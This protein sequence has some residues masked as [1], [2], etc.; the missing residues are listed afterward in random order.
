MEGNEKD[1]NEF[2]KKKLGST[3]TCLYLNAG[4]TMGENRSQ[5]AHIGVVG[6]DTTIVGTPRVGQLGSIPGE[7]PPNTLS[8]HSKPLDEVSISLDGGHGSH[9]D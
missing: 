3:C 4:A 1:S 6:F 2:C 7:G 8:N 5:W 9:M